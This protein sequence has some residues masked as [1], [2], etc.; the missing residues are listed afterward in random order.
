VSQMAIGA[1]VQQG[2]GVSSISRSTP[3]MRRR[4]FLSWRRSPSPAVAGCS[5]S[6]LSCFRHQ[7]AWLRTSPCQ[8]VLGGDLSWRLAIEAHRQGPGP[9][10]P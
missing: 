3:P 9:P 1:M 10:L 6:S 7:L 8:V 5:S 2:A 4:F